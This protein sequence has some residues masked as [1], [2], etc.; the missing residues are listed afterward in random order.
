MARL[1]GSDETLPQR[2]TRLAETMKQETALALARELDET[3]AHCGIR[4][5]IYRLRS[6]SRLCWR[7]GKSLNLMRR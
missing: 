7:R 4:S 5:L 2:V 1:G 6:W 3:P